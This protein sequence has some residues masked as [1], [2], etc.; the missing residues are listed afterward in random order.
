MTADSTSP[1][2]RRRTSLLIGAFLAVQL[3]LPVRS[4][5]QDKHASRG[6]FGWNMYSHLHDC[7]RSYERVRRGGA[8]FPIDTRS[9]LRRHGQ[10]GYLDHRD[11][12]PQ[13]H[14]W[15]CETLITEPGEQL[16]G[17]LR[18]RINERPWVTLVEPGVDLCRAERHGVVGS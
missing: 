16:Q 18:C 2:A 5:V 14:A 7:E 8:R 15:L 13:L 9:L 11:R 3:L 1:A 6:D 17:E 4:F 12:L 10:R